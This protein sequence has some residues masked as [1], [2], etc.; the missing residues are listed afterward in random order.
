MTL[1]PYDPPKTEPPHVESDEPVEAVLKYHHPAWQRVLALSVP[2]SSGLLAL[3]GLE[4]LRDNQPLMAVPFLLLS[5]GGL[6]VA[7]RWTR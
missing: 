1:N 2:F 7:W 5:A 6:L 3:A 4:Y